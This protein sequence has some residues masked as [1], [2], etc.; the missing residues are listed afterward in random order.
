MVDNSIIERKTART[1][2]RQFKGKTQK[3]S[4]RFKAIE[5]FVFLSTTW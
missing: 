5:P 4:R 3:A 2:A 1:M